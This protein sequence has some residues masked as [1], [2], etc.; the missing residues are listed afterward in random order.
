MFEDEESFWK[1]KWGQAA[2]IFWGGVIVY[3]ILAFAMSANMVLALTNIIVDAFLC[4][5][6]LFLWLGF[7]SQFVL[8]VR[9][10]RERWE[11]LTRVWLYLSENVFLGMFGK[12]GPAMFIE[13]GFVHAH[14]G[15]KEEKG[16]GVIWLD[17]ASAA[18][19]RTPT[20]Y[21]R[22]VG[23]GVVFTKKNE[24]IAGTVDL[25]QQ[26]Y[27]I[28]P[29]D[30]DDS[31]TADKTAENYDEVQA[32]RWQTSAMTRDGIEVV[33]TI[34]VNFKLDAEG[35]NP[36]NPQAHEGGTLFGYR[37]ESVEKLVRSMGPVSASNAPLVSDRPLKLAVDVWREYLR[38]FSFNQL[39]EVQD[40]DT[41][42]TGLQISAGM[43]A[44][45][46][47]KPIVNVLDGV[48]KL[49]YQ[50]DVNGHTKID[51]AGKPIPMQ[52]ES[53]EHKQIQEIGY[54]VTG[55]NLKRIQFPPEMEARLMTQWKTTWLKSAE[56]ERDQIERL[57]TQ[58]KTL[59]KGKA[60]KEF[61]YDAAKKL[62]AD[63]QW[64]WEQKLQLGDQNVDVDVDALEITPEQVA[65]SVV[66]ST[67]KRATRDTDLSRRLTGEQAELSEFVQR[68]R[69]VTGGVDDN[70]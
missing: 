2:L 47:T 63:V 68:L 8:P 1:T 13:N 7:F 29:A 23:P 56:K 35:F 28:G 49:M 55:A 24:R 44:E 14:E 27:S 46:L 43:M 37:G 48:G 65:E 59:G 19:L 22:A 45:R 5:F 54:R 18:M 26:M 66:R 25:H 53:R 36:N 69:G 10:L 62:R 60:V 21:T 3:L 33:V 61:A 64:L 39:Y 34:N 67:F 40:E 17:S 52:E 70:A 51:E 16:S 31:F 15:E 32:R 57:H 12:H 42:K 11:I 38:K 41:G 30:S 50:Q 9:S 6:G 58:R 4:V 20:K